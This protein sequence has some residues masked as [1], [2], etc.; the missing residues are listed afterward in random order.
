M[1]V[2]THAVLGVLC[3]CVLYFHIYTCSAQLSMFH[4]DGSRP[5]WCIS[6]IIYSRYTSLV[7]N[8]RIM[9]RRCRSVVIVIIIISRNMVIVIIVVVIIIIIVVV[10]TGNL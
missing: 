6:S 2:T 7:G 4:I 1:I 10:I 8:P 5:Q 3:V 9:E